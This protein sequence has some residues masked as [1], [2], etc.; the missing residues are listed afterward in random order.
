[1]RELLCVLFSLTTSA[2]IFS[3]VDGDDD[4]PLGGSRTVEG[5]VVDFETGQPISG[6]ASVSA[7]GLVPAPMIT[8][9]GAGFTIEGVP[10]NSAFQILASAPSHR[11]TFSESVIVGTED[12]R[13]VRAAVVSEA[14]LAGL[15]D[16]FGI[17]PSA[18]RG[19]LLARVV[20]ER[21]EPKAG[22]AASNFV[23][24]GASVSGP[25]FLGDNRQPLPAATATSSSGWVVYFEVAPGI[26]ELGQAA[27]A[28][29]TL[30][31]PVSPIN[32]GTITIAEIRAIDGAAVLPQNVLFETQIFPIFNKRG[33]VACHSG[34]GPGK[35]L[36][37]LMLDA[38]ANLTYRELREENPLRVQ[39][40]APEKSL[41]LTYPSREDPADRH[42]NVTFLSALDPDY[43][44]ILVWIREGAKDN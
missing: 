19:V 32:S 1:M 40:A 41:I 12:V 16:G 34:G 30:D 44:K 38:G 15:A 4:E 5:T 42:P 23:L 33:C 22:V 11:A 21:G 26:V 13:D 14:F 39:L 36:G 7:S 10:D 31:M 25:H 9:Q 17:M 24:S 29:V 8:S 43:L 28:T 18:A 2:C 3:S 37:G 6:A 27:T 20:D 35:D